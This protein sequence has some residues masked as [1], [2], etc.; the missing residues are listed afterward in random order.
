MLLIRFTMTVSVLLIK[1]IMEMGAGAS[2]ALP[3]FV[4]IDVDPPVPPW[5]ICLPIETYT[6]AP[7]VKPLKYARSM[8]ILTAYST[9]INI[10][11]CVRN[12][13]CMICSCIVNR[14]PQFA[15]FRSVT[16][17]RTLDSAYIF[18]MWK[19]KFSWLCSRIA[20]YLLCCCNTPTNIYKPYKQTSNWM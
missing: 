14:K 3:Q 8:H 6:T 11:L 16:L 15:N 4:N 12:C 10:S 18:K 19:S 20:M 1:I 9:F 17:L 2:F 5:N 13:L 7:L